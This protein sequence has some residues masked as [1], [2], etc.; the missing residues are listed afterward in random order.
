[1]STSPS[2]PN[3]DVNKPADSLS[4]S[5]PQL[6]P[7]SSVSSCYYGDKLRVVGQCKWFNPIKGYGFLTIVSPHVDHGKDIFVHH[8]GIKPNTT[9]Y[10]TL[11][12]GEYVSFDLSDGA[13]GPQAVEVTGVFGGLLMCDVTSVLPSK[14]AT[15]EQEHEQDISSNHRQQPPS[16]QQFQD[17]K[18]RQRRRV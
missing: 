11:T 18:R 6:P 12:R 9:T 13:K 5:L 15:Q 1:M 10:K 14:S 3:S 4:S 2:T 17:N 8:S 7:T 16:Q